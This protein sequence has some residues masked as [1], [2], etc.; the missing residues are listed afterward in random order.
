MVAKKRFSISLPAKETEV[1]KEFC[2]DIG[3]SFSGLLSQLMIGMYKEITS[4]EGLFSKSW[5]DWTMKEKEEFMQ[6]LTDRDP[7]VFNRESINRDYPG[8][9]AG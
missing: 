4:N 7:R 2:S 3:V 9:I 1:V 5:S 6:A 8:K